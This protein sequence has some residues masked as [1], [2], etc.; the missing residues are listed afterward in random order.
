MK[1]QKEKAVSASTTK[2]KVDIRLKILSVNACQKTAKQP[3]NISISDEKAS[4]MEVDLVSANHR[5]QELGL[6]DTQTRWHAID[7]ST[8]LKDQSIKSSHAWF[9]CMN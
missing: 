9:K 3:D 1:N 8:L 5:L 6:P 7:L 2:K 4:L